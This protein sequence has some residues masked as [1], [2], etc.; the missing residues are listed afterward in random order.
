MANGTK[1]YEIALHQVKLNRAA[2]AFEYEDITMI[3]PVREAFGDGGPEG[4]DM[5]VII[6]GLDVAFCA[7]QPHQLGAGSPRGFE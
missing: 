4:F 3:L 1:V 2:C 5:F 6:S 7:P